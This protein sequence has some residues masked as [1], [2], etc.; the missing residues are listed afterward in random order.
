MMA[1]PS[2]FVGLVT[3]PGVIVHEAAQQS[4]CRL[5]QVAVF[6]V[7]YF[8]VSSPPGYVAHERVR[9]FNTAFLLSAGPLLVNSLLCVVFCF[10]AFVP[11]RA[12]GIENPWSYFFLWLGLSIGMHAFP[13]IED[14]E[15]LRDLARQAVRNGNLLALVSFPLVILMGFRDSE[16]PPACGD[17]A[18]RVPVPGSKRRSW[19]PELLVLVAAAH[20]VRY[21]LFDAIYASFLGLGLPEL[22]L[23]KLA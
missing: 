6:D 22:L 4:F 1:I 23:W 18:A 7:C 5:R 11:V 9:D 3:F 20:L 10:P 15:Q 19:G 12:F 17:R 21:V 16:T 14:A 13:S 2:W 8:R